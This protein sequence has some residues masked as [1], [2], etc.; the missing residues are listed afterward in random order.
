MKNIQFYHECSER[1]KRQN[2]EDA[3]E[4]EPVESTVWT[5]VDNETTEGPLPDPDED[6]AH[7]NDLISEADID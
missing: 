5:S 7:L 6:M 1:A 4:N 2:G 3:H